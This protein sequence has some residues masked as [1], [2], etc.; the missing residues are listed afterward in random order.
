MKKIYALY[1]SSEKGKSETIKILLEKLKLKYPEHKIMNIIS[2][3]Y[4]GDIRVVI[5]I[6]DRIIAIESQGDPN[7]RIFK[8]IP[9]FVNINADIIICATRTRGETVKLVERQKDKYEIVWIRKES[10]INKSEYTTDNQKIAEKIL[11]KIEIDL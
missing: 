2:P 4:S 10:S 3:I 1:G 6:N 8:S 9:E 7:S 11:E 5:K